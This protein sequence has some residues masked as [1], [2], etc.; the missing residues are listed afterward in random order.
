ML[1]AI[2][3][4]FSKALFAAKFYGFLDSRDGSV[5]DVTSPDGS[6]RAV[7]VGDDSGWSRGEVPLPAT[8]EL[9]IAATSMLSRFGA[10]RTPDSPAAV[11]AF[12]KTA[13]RGLP[14]EWTGNRWDGEVP[15][16][17][18]GFR[19]ILERHPKDGTSVVVRQER[20]KSRLAASIRRQLRRDPMG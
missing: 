1:K 3:G 18:G 11:R 17:L 2:D 6:R 5:C 10:W 4:A 14:G 20:P 9:S 19:L 15:G 7:F 8:S 13:L 16:P 12:Y